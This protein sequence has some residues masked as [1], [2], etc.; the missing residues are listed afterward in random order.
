MSFYRRRIHKQTSPLWLHTTGWVTH[1]DTHT[2]WGAGLW[3][4]SLALISAAEFLQSFVSK[5][6]LWGRAE[7]GATSS[8]SPSFPTPSLPRSLLLNMQIQQRMRLLVGFVARIGSAATSQRFKS[9]AGFSLENSRRSSGSSGGE[10][11]CLLQ[12][13]GPQSE[14]ILVFLSCA[15]Y[16]WFS[17]PDT[18]S[19]VR[20]TLKVEHEEIDV[21]GF[22]YYT[23]SPIFFFP[24]FLCHFCL[25]WLWK[26]FWAD[27]ICSN[28][29]CTDSCHR[30]ALI[31]K[32]M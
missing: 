24:I 10:R 3:V 30:I 1:T 4:S 19:Y 16:E 9:E 11:D 5:C 6:E 12:D 14:R 31:L 32:K 21:K 22:C 25:A 2:K 7:K 23:L 28:H 26:M 13:R 18:G 29:R 20:N 8:S 15:V 17:E 27:S